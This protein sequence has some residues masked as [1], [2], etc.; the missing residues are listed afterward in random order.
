MCGKMFLQKVKHKTQI[1]SNYQSNRD[2]N[3]KFYLDLTQTTVACNIP[4]TTLNPFKDVIQKCV[5]GEYKNVVVPD[6]LTLR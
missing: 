4:W 2:T 6:E 5:N 1:V 3:Q